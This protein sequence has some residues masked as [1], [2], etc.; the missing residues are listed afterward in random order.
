MTIPTV[1]AHKQILQVFQ[2]YMLFLYATLTAMI[3][4]YNNK[5]IFQITMPIN[6]QHVSNNT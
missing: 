2:F 4:K 5:S 6:M 1:T 3:F